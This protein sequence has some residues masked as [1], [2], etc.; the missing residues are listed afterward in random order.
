M[1]DAAHSPA[2]PDLESGAVPSTTPADAPVPAGLPRP[3][4]VALMVPFLA[5]IL[6]A[7]GSLWRE[8]QGL[9]VDMTR[10][11]NSVIVGYTNIHPNPTYAARPRNWYREEGDELHLWSGWKDNSH[12]WFRIRKGELDRER[13]SLPVGRDTVRA[14]DHTILESQG[15]DRWVRVP[16]DTPVIGMRDGEWSRV[17]PLRLLDKVEVVNEPGQQQPLLI[18]FTR[19]FGLLE[20]VTVFDPNLDGQR[21]TMGLTGYHYDRKPLLYDRG[22]ESLWSIQ[23]GH[24]VALAGPKKGAKLKSLGKP[25]PVTWASWRDENPGTRLIVGAD[26]GRP[27]P[28]N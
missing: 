24:L 17:Y 21:L 26:R 3:V 19:S 7:T 18:T 8:A 11:R 28:T 12:Q 23:D 13:L 9:M 4:T 2:T 20:A 10:V 14:I 5:F 1:A 25:A 15:G 6:Y 22:S 27:M 16:D